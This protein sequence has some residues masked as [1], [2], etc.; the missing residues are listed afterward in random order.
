MEHVTEA[1]ATYSKMPGLPA[2]PDREYWENLKNKFTLIK[3]NTFLKIQK[4]SIGEGKTCFAFKI[5]DE[6]RG[7]EMIGK[8]DKQVYQG[9]SK[10]TD[11]VTA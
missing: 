9:T 11:L 7:C 2:G 5:Y 10:K 8:I 6:V 1:E 3:S 4:I